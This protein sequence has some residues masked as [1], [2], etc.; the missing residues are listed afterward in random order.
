MPRSGLKTKAPFAHRSEEDFA[1]I[2]DFYKVRWEYEPHTFV[3]ERDEA[4]G[5]RES[6]TPDFYLPEHHTYI[7][8][9]TRKKNLGP[10]KRH[11]LERLRQLYPDVRVRLFHPKDLEK[12]VLRFVGAGGNEAA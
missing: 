3:L 12:L 7:E 11:R 1:R 10:R 6:F 5:I 8:L 4:G 2:L 9:T